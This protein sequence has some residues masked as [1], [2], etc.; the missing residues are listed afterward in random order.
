MVTAGVTVVHRP[1]V[2]VVARLL[3]PVV[4]VA[5][6]LQLVV[7]AQ[8]LVVVVVAVQRTFINLSLKYSLT[9]CLHSDGSTNPGN[10]L[11]V[12]GLSSRVDN[13]ALEELFAKYGRVSSFSFTALRHA[14]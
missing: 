5:V 2:E 14:V 10:N 13:R 4:R 8:L 7:V 9:R 1:V 3:H 6:A 12:S 11:H